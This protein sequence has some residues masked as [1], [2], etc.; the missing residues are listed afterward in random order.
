MLRANMMAICDGSGMPFARGTDVRLSS[1]GSG[2][3]FVL[4]LRSD[5]VL[6]GVNSVRS[7][8]SA[9][10]AGVKLI[11]NACNKTNQPIGTKDEV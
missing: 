11:R 7:S 5:F 3:L 2:R 1:A 4:D 10:V 6:F 9:R 8:E